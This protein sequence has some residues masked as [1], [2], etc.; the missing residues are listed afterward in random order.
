MVDIDL[1]TVIKFC[2]RF[3][4]EYLEELH[5]NAGRLKTAAASVSA[6]LGNTPMATGA[7]DKLEQVASAIYKASSVGEE[8]I[9]EL[10]R[11][12]QRELEHKN[13]IENMCR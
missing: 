10:K 3:E 2:E 11:K 6:T 4:K 12:T 5:A 7:S 8:R 13:K 1:E 9:R